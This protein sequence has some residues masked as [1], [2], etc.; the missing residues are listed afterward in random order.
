MRRKAT[1]DQLTVWRRDG[2]ELRMYDGGTDDDGREVVS[3][4]LH[5]HQWGYGRDLFRGRNYR[6]SPLYAVDSPE[7]IAG[8]LSFL[9]LREGDTDSE[10]FDAYTDRQI[11][12]RDSHRCE[13]LQLLVHELEGDT[14]G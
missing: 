3:Y 9:S 2:Y 6:P 14:D 12:W 11:G 7:S 1:A 13:E 5:D 8:L 4:V 10:Y